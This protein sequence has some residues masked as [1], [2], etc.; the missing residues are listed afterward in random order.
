MYQKVSNS[1]RTVWKN[2]NASL[3]PKFTFKYFL[4]F[5]LTFCEPLVSPHPKLDENLDTIV[6]GLNPS[7]ERGNIHTFST[8]GPQ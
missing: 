8:Q 5:N 1:A 2:M 6:S 4:L 3:R 7:D